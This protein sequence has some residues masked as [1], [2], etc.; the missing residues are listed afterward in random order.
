[1]ASPGGVE[2]A[3]ISTRVVADTS[4]LLEELQADLRRIE[5]SVALDVSASVD[6]AELV[7][8]AREAVTEAQAL[9]GDIDVR[10]NVDS[11][12]IGQLESALRN[13]S[14][15]VFSL[16]GNF[17]L[18]AGGGVA[19]GLALIPLTAVIG[20]LVAALAAPIAVAAGGV[21]IFG[22]LAGF[23]L[24]DTLAQLKA[25]D[26]QRKKLSDLTKGTQE[27]ADA[28]SDLRV[29][30]AGLSPA[31]RAF[32]RALD[33]VK[34][35]FADFPKGV[36][37]KPLTD[38]LKLLA[39]LLPS[40]EPIAKAVSGVLSDLL[41]DLDKAVKSPGFKRFVQAFAHDLGRDLRVLASIMGNVFD[42]LAGLFGALDDSLSQGV[43]KGLDDITGKFADFGRDAKNNEGLKSFVSYVKQNMPKVGDLISN[44]FGLLGDALKVLAPLGS[45]VL[46]FLNGIVGAIRDLGAV[47]GPLSGALAL[48]GIA[49]FFGGPEVGLA[50]GAVV[51]LAAGF[52]H[53]YDNSRPLRSLLHDIG[54]YFTK[55]WL[56]IIRDAARDV[57]P[58]FKDAIKDVSDTIRN[59]QGLFKVLGEVIVAL[60]SAAVIGAIEQTSLAIRGI[61]KAFK[62]GTAAVKLWANVTITLFRVILKGVKALVTVI[63]SQFTTIVDGAAAAFGWLPGVGGDIKNAQK[64]FHEF[65][66]GITDGIDTADGALRDL[67]TQINE[68]GQKHP[69][70]HIDSNTLDLIKQMHTIDA[71][72]FRDK[73][74]TVTAHF[75]QEIERVRAPGGGMGRPG[76]I[77]SG[78]SGGGRGGVNIN[79]DKV[80]TRDVDDLLRKTDSIRRGRAG[81]GVALM[82]A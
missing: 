38:A 64:R 27:Y 6:S 60:G 42:G 12:Q 52:K 23:A 26:E 58:A 44:S 32:A 16:V 74:F 71:F 4:H 24:K 61:A 51:A 49:A 65:T 20:G 8:S 53:L 14:S 13:A 21:T 80:E 7:A 18:L 81:G 1:M 79:I 25:I 2:V 46:D 31:Q 34:G 43:L 10:A 66:D 55:T 82:G 15:G 30:T 5:K 76:D 48:G 67:Q 33:Q 77:Q 70:F 11:S 3:R 73:D 29:L 63:L 62:F 35:A 75:E 72:K 78:N 41:G 68:V 50:V 22:F 19:L 47:A 45:G 54:D 28:Q 40:L 57:V 69:R 17:S 37:L 56:P 39:D 9:A 36:L 59:N